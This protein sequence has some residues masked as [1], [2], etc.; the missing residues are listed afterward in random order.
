MPIDSLT[1]VF[2]A[3]AGMNVNAGAKSGQDGERM[4]HQIGYA[5]TVLDST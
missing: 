4:Q 2:P 3:G 5:A 1:K